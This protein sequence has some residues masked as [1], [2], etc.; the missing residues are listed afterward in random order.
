MK[1]LLLAAA[2]AA[3]T[4]PALAAA[5]SSPAAEAPRPDADPALWVVRDADTTIY[6]FGTFHLLDGRRDW[7][8]DEVRAAFDRSDELVL[9]LV[10][11]DN[12]ADAQPVIMR[13]AG[14]PAG[15][16]LAQRLPAALHHRLNEALPRMG[17]PAGAF[18]LLDPW[19]AAMSLFSIGAQRLGITGA[20]GTE[21]TLTAAARTRNMPV[22]GIETIEAQ[23]EM[24]DAMPEA[25]QVQQLGLTI[26]AMD[27][28]GETLAPMTEA[29]AAGDS[30][31]LYEIMN[32][33]LAQSPDLYR[34][35]L[36]ERYAR[37]TD[38]IRDRMARPG[39]LFVAVGAG[40]LAG[41][42][43][44]QAMLARHGLRAERVR[45]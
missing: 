31:R 42:D 17:V 28:L 22:S 43:S 41:R 14:D 19:F 39:T 37:W 5:P 45:P 38:W 26:D 44:V 2:L 29:W 36:V 7:F 1:K 21:M 23:M 18:D 33:Q 30:E 12:P 32:G 27:R 6:L 15:R 9:E 35:M 20:E 34:T 24:L 11:P 3:V 40:H 13:Y 16:T 25:Q 10:L 4:A 8:N